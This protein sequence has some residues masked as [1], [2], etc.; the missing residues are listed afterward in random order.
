MLSVLV[1]VQG[2]V[3]GIYVLKG[4]PFDLT[5]QAIKTTRDWRMEPGQK[6]GKPVPVRVSIEIG[7]R[8]LSG[9]AQN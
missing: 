1:D 3:S 8:L 2:H 6:D 5:G 7:F 4:A 9:P